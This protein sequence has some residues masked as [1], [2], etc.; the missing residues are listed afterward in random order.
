[1]RI[2]N[3]EGVIRRRILVNYRVDPSV[4]QQQL[5]SRF[6]PKLQ[7]GYAVA[8]ICLI[9]L[10]RIRPS[11][12]PALFGF[13]SENA[14]HRVA[15]TWEEDGKTREGVYIPRRDTTSLMNRLAGGRV[16]P[17]EHHKARFKIT[18][19]ENHI[20]FRLESADHLVKVELS[21]ALAAEIPSESCF[22]SLAE[23]SKFF[24]AGSLGYSATADKRTL[25]GLV[26]GTD[27]WKVEPLAIE[28]VYSSYFTD[29][30]I[31]PRGS[32]AFDCALIMRNIRCQWRAAN[33][34]YV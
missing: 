26:L 22:G 14:A 27:Q 17:G 2:P 25:D 13:S 11:H 19:R 10:E 15:V 31:F 32:A 3:I 6:E 16:F 21:G 9:R 33:D 24:E 4:I 18:E 30:G 29:Q 8:G 7:N 23:A 12:V 5:P 34:L 20:D 28:R 1:M